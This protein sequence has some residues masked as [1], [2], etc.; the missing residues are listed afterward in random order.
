V[1]KAH[2]I[3]ARVWDSV[4]RLGGQPEQRHRAELVGGARG[5]VLEVGAGTGLNF[6]LYVPGA[7]VFAVEP[8]PHMAATAAERARTASAAVHVARG[9]AEALPFPDHVFDTVVACYVLCS[10]AEPA[11]ALAEIRRVLR[12]GGELRVY[13]HVRSEATWPA[14]FQDAVT[15]VWH[16]CCCNCHPNRDTLATIRDAGFEVETRPASYGPPTP[17]RPHILGVARPR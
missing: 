1:V 8:E 17:V 5:Q 16:R 4:V 13:E 9:V 10:V 6:R 15:P 14:R 12:R 11:R 7:T 3:F 2:P